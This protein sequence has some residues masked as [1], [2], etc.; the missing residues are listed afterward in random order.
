MDEKTK[1]T[2]NSLS[3]VPMKENFEDLHY[4]DTRCAGWSDPWVAKIGHLGLGTSCEIKDMEKE[5]RDNKVA[6]Q[7]KKWDEQWA[8]VCNKDKSAGRTR[9]AQEKLKQIENLLIYAIE[10][11]NGAIWDSLKDTKKFG[12]P[13]PKSTL[14]ERLGKIAIPVRPAYREL[15]QKPEKGLYVPIPLQE[16]RNS[17]GELTP[18]HLGE[19]IRQ[20]E[21][22][23]QEAITAWQKS[24]HETNSFN[25]NLRKQYTK[26]LK[27]YEEEKQTVTERINERIDALEEDWEREKEAYNNNQKEFNDKIEKLK[28][29]YFHKNTDAVIQ[30]CEMILNN[31]KYPDTFLKNFE[32][33]YNPENKILII[34]YELPSLERFPKVKEVKYI[35]SNNE[36]KEYHISESQFN[37]MFDDATYKITLRSLHEIFEADAV[38]AIDAISFNGWVKSINKASGNEETNC[39]LTI[40]VKKNEFLKINLSNVD[41]K[42]CFKYLKGVAS[43]KL[44]S[45]TPVQPILQMSRMDKRFVDGYNVTNGIDNTTNLAAMDWEDFEHLI[46]ELFEQEFQVNGGEVKVTQASRD[47]GVDAIAFDPDPIRGGKIVI[48]AKRYTNTISVSA[49]RDL[50]GT[51]LNEGATKGILVSTADYG[52]DAYEFAKGKPIT[53][54]SGSNL[55]HLLEKHGHHAKIDLRDAKRILAEKDKPTS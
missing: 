52:P 45:L 51:V 41:P 37:K 39:I 14:R 2:A 30:Y 34:E 31:S 32:L 43:S 42:T 27:E 48:Q 47:G 8:K 20:K 5:R 4:S 9:Y 3:A 15:P 54:L 21:T 40:Q 49:V 46:R 29:S 6:A 23:D 50:Y 36:L 7:F 25:F 38:E 28:E 11:D 13:N 17:R 1:T 53:L 35:A 18:V 22:R 24:V 44:S 26:E 10:N 55:L 19:I 16:F 12:V 33:E